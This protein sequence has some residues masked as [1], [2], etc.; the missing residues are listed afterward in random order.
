MSR[1]QLSTAKLS[2]NEKSYA[3]HENLPKE[4]ERR[5]SRLQTTY[6]TLLL[7]CETLLRK[8]FLP[9]PLPFD[10]KSLLQLILFFFLGTKMSGTVLFERQTQT[11]A[12]TV[13]A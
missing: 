1:C 2:D 10:L 3:A 8:L 12:T 5:L 11:E 13:A 4:N 6:C 9:L 7:S